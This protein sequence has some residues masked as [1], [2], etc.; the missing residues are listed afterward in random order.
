M[1]PGPMLITLA[2]MMM[3][4]LDALDVRSDVGFFL[5]IY[6]VEIRGELL[7]NKF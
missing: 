3:G 7:K 4:M 6:E 5:F 1:V 2:F